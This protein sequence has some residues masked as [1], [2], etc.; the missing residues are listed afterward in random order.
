[1]KSTKGPTKK[2]VIEV[3]PDPPYVLRVKTLRGALV[4]APSLGKGYKYAYSQPGKPGRR[5]FVGPLALTETFDPIDYPV[6]IEVL[7]RHGEPLSGPVFL[8]PE[9]PAAQ[10]EVTPLPVG[11]YQRRYNTWMQQ[12]HRRKRGIVPRQHTPRSYRTL[13]TQLDQVTATLLEK[14][15][16]AT[17]ASPT[18]AK[19]LATQQ[20]PA[21]LETLRALVDDLHELA[22]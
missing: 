20:I 8:D 1:M 7:D 13:S 3:A 11:E 15:D 14:I 5:K 4:H 9:H 21:D 22:Y 18:T 6:W 12:E 10:D 17:A 19:L 16:A 2:P